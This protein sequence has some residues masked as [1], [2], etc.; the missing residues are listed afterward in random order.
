MNYIM[1]YKLILFKDLVDEFLSDDFDVVV[2][3]NVQTL[4]TICSEKVCLL[5]R[6]EPLAWKLCSIF[7][8]YKIP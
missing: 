4:E 8:I 1:T 7:Y 6:I 2:E 3:L 5:N